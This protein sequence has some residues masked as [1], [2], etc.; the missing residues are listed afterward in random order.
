MSAA[1]ALAMPDAVLPESTGPRGVEPLCAWYSTVCIAAIESGVARG[2]AP[3][4]GFH[5]DIRVRRLPL[6]RV[7]ALGDPATLFQ[8]LNTPADRVAAERRFDASR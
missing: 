8:N 1:A 2:D 7:R 6:E 3:L 4:I 5:Q